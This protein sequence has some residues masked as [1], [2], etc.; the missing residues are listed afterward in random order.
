MTVKIIGALLVILS[1]GSIG[2]AK[3]AACRKEEK[4]LQELILTLEYMESELQYRLPCLPELCALAAQHTAGAIGKIMSALSQELDRQQ[5][6]DAE[7]CMQTVLNGFPMPASVHQNLSLLG[8]SLG[9]FHLSGQLT[10]MNTVKALCRRELDRL[11]VM[12]EQRLRSY[13]TLGICAGVAL[14]IL[15]I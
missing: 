7:G 8:K 9:R 10:G 2:F 13:Q 14:V 4:C 12:Q 1:C 3:V 15:F 6:S 5:S 11:R